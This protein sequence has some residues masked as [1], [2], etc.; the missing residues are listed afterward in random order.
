M[1]VCAHV[2]KN[3]LCSCLLYLMN[4]ASCCLCHAGYEGLEHT[5]KLGEVQESKVPFFEHPVAD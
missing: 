3:L 2:E 5:D 4:A 1:G